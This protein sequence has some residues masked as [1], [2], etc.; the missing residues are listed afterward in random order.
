MASTP[1]ILARTPL[2]TLHGTFDCVA[3]ADPGDPSVTHV[4]MVRGDIEGDA[5]VPVRVHSECFTGE[6]L[7]SVK[8]DCRRQ[9]DAALDHIDAAGRGVVV[10]L[11]QEGR[12]IGLVA[13]LKA[14]ALQAGEGLDT[15]DANRRLGLPDDARSYEVAA[16]ILTALGVRRVELLTNNPAKVAGLEAAGIEVVARVPV[17]VAQGEAAQRYLETK[18]ARMGHVLGPDGAG[19]GADVDEKGG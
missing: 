3:F 19:D 14:Y 4:A 18:V 1:E 2:P 12:G 7:H 10:Y 13:K 9:L 5:P 6:V 16:G 8:C 17:V 11:R 15:V